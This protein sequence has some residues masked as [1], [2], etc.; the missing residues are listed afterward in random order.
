[1]SDDERRELLLD[2][3]AELTVSFLDR[4]ERDINVGRVSFVR[5]LLVDFLWELDQKPLPPIEERKQ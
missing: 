1:M 5:R 3:Y 2:K 4:R